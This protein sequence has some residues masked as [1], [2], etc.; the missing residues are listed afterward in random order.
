MRVAIA[1]KSSRTADGEANFV[2]PEAFGVELGLA[3]FGLCFHRPGNRATPPK[4]STHYSVGRT[5]V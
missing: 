1:A 4:F 3:G 5:T 2:L